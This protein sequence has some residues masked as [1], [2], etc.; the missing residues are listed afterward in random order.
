MRTAWCVSS[1]PPSHLL[2]FFIL[3]PSS[4]ILHPSSFILHPSS[5]ILHPSSLILHPSSF[6]PHPSSFILHPSSFIPHP[7]YAARFTTFSAAS[8]IP[9]ATVKLSPD[10]RIT[11]WPSSTLVPSSRTTTGTLTPSFF[12]ASTTPRATMS[13]RTMP[14]N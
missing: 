3:H 14:P 8:F 9:S 10:S 12:A 11:R 1:S 5:F 13:Q 2:P 6:I 7:R 4:F